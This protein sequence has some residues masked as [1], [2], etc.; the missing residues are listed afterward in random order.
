MR[1]H[2]HYHDLYPPDEIRR[3]RHRLGVS[4]AGMAALVGVSPN[5]V[6]RWEQGNRA[7]TWRLVPRLRE[8][9]AKLEAATPLTS[10]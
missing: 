2:P 7:P 5:T 6:A 1:Q 10:V 3:L 8:L 4:Q 9:E